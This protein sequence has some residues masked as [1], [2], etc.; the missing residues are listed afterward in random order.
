MVLLPGCDG[1][2]L[3]SPA[4][5]RLDAPASQDSLT[6]PPVLPAPA[7]ARGG[8]QRGAVEAADASCDGERRIDLEDEVVDEDA[9]VDAV[10]RRQVRHRVRVAEGDEA[11]GDGAV[12]LAHEVAVAE[13][14]AE[15]GDEPRL[16]VVRGEEV[17]DRL[18]QPGAGR[19]GGAA[20]GLVDVEAVVARA[21]G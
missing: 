15:G 10:L 13:A 20:L 9:L 17:G 21:E 7:S 8:G 4:P 3:A 11:V 6:L 14:V 12:G 16:R 5:A 1:T 19:G 2:H 18:V